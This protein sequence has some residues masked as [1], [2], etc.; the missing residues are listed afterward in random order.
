MENTRLVEHRYIKR[1]EA[2]CFWQFQF[3]REPFKET[4]AFY[5]KDFGS[6][7]ASLAAEREHRDAFFRA[8]A[9]LGFVG[10][11]G[12]IHI[13]PIPLQLVI[14]PRNKS[15]IIGVSREVTVGRPK[16]PP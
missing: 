5:D 14:S 15:G 7:T 8:A 10:P 13:D 12:S 2:E 4:K 1:R 11:D 16:R 9:E 3:E 6:K